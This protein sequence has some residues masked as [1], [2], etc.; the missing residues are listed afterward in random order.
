MI[1][2]HRAR[3]IRLKVWAGVVLLGLA[4]VSAKTLTLNTPGLVVDSGLHAHVRVTFSGPGPIL[5]FAFVLI[6]NLFLFLGAF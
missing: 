1:A 2:A 4:A 5:F 6:L 3:K